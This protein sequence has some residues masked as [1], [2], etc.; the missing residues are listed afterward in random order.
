MY[1]ES[2]VVD[3]CLFAVILGLCAKV[4]GGTD[5]GSTLRKYSSAGDTATVRLFIF[6]LNNL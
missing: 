5:G 2:E 4:Q 6:F 1:L 3:G